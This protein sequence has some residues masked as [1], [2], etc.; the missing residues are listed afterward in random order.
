MAKKKSI[1]NSS[2][3]AQISDLHHFRQLFMQNMEPILKT[4]FN[5]KMA[6]VCYWRLPIES[7]KEKY[8]ELVNTL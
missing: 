6:I 5:F 3:Y 8:T 2:A 4:N 1:E 7:V